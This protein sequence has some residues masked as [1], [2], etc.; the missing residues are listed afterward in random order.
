MGDYKISQSLVP[1][2][3]VSLKHREAVGD[4]K[5][6][7][8]PLKN[9]DANNT[10]EKI[11]SFGD[12]LNPSLGKSSA[13]TQG[14]WWGNTFGSLVRAC[15]S[16]EVVMSEYVEGRGH[17]VGIRHNARDI[18]LYG[19]LDA[20]SLKSLKTG[21]RIPNGAPLGFALERFYFEARRGSDAIDPDVVTGPLENI[22]S[23]N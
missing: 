21:M 3:P 13:K 11:Y 16:G 22:R 15:A 10:F 5:C 19:N 2:K 8:F 4:F 17:V 7:R 20:T 9:E 23:A 18:T 14:V 12:Y 1:T 6:E